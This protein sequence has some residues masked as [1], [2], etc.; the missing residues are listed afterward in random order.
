MTHYIRF[1]ND[2]LIRE[3][4]KRNVTSV[5]EVHFETQTHDKICQRFGLF[6]VLFEMHYSFL[7]H[8]VVEVELLPSQIV[9]RLVVSFFFIS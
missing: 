5:E 1:I 3:Q 4:E 8:C 7:I 9:L 2:E 6:V